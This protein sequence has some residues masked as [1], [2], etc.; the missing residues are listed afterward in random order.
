MLHHGILAKKIELE[1]VLFEIFKIYEQ[2]EMDLCIL[3]IDNKNIKKI[4]ELSILWIKLTKILDAYIYPLDDKI[5][6]MKTK[7]LDFKNKIILRYSTCE[8]II[9]DTCVDSYG[10][11]ALYASDDKSAVHLSKT[12]D[13]YG[14][15]SQSYSNKK[16]PLHVLDDVYERLVRI[17]PDTTDVSQIKNQSKNYNPVRHWMKGIQMVAINWQYKDKYWYI[18]NL[19]FKNGAYRIKPEHLITKEKKPKC[20]FELS[21]NISSEIKIITDV[22]LDDYSFTFG[23]NTNENKSF[24]RRL[25]IANNSCKFKSE[26][27]ITETY[28]KIFSIKIICRQNEVY[29]IPFE[30][31]ETI[32]LTNK[33][34]DSSIYNYNDKWI[35]FDKKT[36][37]LLPVPKIDIFKVL[38]SYKM[39][40]ID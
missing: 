12:D 4:D 30:C 11:P 40:K 34:Y 16:I 31:F 13:K 37:N 26:P 21:I 24:K 28:F 3:S 1:K 38:V 2:N 22:I 15:L 23:E 17:Y 32:F 14:T 5:N 6:V 29:I 25:L 18:Y 27:I 9:K 19:F 35:K 33:I 8:I 10:K 36:C 20:K 7:L 39:E